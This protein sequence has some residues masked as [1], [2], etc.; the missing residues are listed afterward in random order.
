MT[1]KDRITLLRGGY[2]KKEIEALIEAEAKA[3][4]K[5]EVKEEVKEVPAE[6]LKNDTKEVPAENVNTF[7]SVMKSLIDEV[8]DL[9]NTIYENNLNNVE[10]D[11][12]V[13]LENEAEKVL[14][15]LINPFNK[16]ENKNGS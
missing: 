4:I 15:S 9:K 13:N 12:K 14:A 3:D 5:E 2:S 6:N 16:E 10:I 11:N 7:E 1:L 8:K